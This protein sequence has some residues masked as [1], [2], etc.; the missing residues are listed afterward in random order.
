MQTHCEGDDGAGD[1][2]GGGG[3]DNQGQQ[4]QQQN[5]ANNSGDE[6][7]NQN[8][9]ITDGTM[10]DTESSDA[11]KPSNNSD[12]NSN[13]NNQNVNAN[14]ND[15]K[16]QFDTHVESLNLGG[17]V[18]VAQVQQDMAQGNTESFAA[19][20]KTTGEAAYKAAITD[21]NKLMQTQ[22]KAAVAEAVGEA[23]GNFKSDMAIRDLHSALPYTEDAALAPVAK[24]V[25]TQF[26]KKGQTQAEAI[27]STDE[28][29]KHSMKLLGGSLD[30]DKSNG[31]PGGR[32]GNAVN[33]DNSGGN[34]D[35][36]DD[37]DWLEFLGAAPAEQQ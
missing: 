15:G 25:F 26:L 18:D 17:G 2:G 20:L 19:A 22:I 29:F 11:G 12:Q 32:F 13:A 21:S 6:N 23:N 1:T 4:Q 24:G 33:N 28:Y 27:K 7:N 31:K 5:N 10:W 14:N 35:G 8:N 34:N 36:T 3:G 37:T 30:K 16:S 9:I